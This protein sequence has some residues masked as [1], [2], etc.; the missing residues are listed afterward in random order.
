MTVNTGDAL[1]WS[2]GEKLRFSTMTC[3]RSSC[4]FLGLI[5]RTIMSMI[6]NERSRRKDRKRK[7]QQ[8]QPLSDAVEVLRD[9]M[10]VRGGGRVMEV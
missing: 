2:V 10:V 7:R 5:A 6:A 8:Q 4:G 1:D 3:C 9:D